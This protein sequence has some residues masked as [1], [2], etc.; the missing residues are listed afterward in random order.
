M[1]PDRARCEFRGDGI[2]LRP[3]RRGDIHALYQAVRESIGTVGRWLPWC[4]ERYARSDSEAWIERCLSVWAAGEE[5]PF[6]IFDTDGSRVLGGVGLNK[7]DR[8][9]RMANLGYWVRASAERQGIATQAVRRISTFGFDLG[10]AQFEIVA[11]SDNIASRRVAEKSGARFQ[12][13]ERGRIHFRER[14]LDAAVYL[15]SAPEQKAA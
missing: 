3:W 12:R 5:F 8:Y 2:V 13:I 7:F 11:A 1:T 4:H 9:R 10:F 6:A 14:K 15:L